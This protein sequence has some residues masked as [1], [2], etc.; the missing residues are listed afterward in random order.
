MD[1]NTY[2]IETTIGTLQVIMWDWDRAVVSN[3]YGIL[4][5]INGVNFCSVRF[6]A[7][8]KDG[9]WQE[10]NN[11]HIS[12][13]RTDWGN[14]SKVARKTLRQVGLWAINEVVLANPKCGVNAH[15]SKLKDEIARTDE[16]IR[17]KMLEVEQLQEKMQLLR[18]ELVGIRT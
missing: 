9:K 5:T 2:T 8:L 14:I 3:P 11:E 6:S 18:N 17:G 4:T 7:K 15:K 13:S 16:K 1:G 10:D 12:L